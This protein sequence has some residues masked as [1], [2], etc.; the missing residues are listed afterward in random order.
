MKE[1]KFRVWNPKIKKL[2][3]W[4]L[5]IQE[6]DRLSL[7]SLDGWKTM[8]FTGLQDKN[9]KEIYEGDICKYFFYDNP[10]GEIDEVK[11]FERYAQYRLG[12]YPFGMDGF[13]DCEVIGNIYEN[14]ELASE[15]GEGGLN[16]RS[17]KE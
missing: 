6:C 16:E 15:R 4:E 12:G 2:I 9:G 14:P 7:L 17:H 3:S 11:Y 5:I 1:I 8:Q 10:I 13:H